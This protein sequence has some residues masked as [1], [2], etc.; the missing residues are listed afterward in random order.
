MTRRLSISPR[1]DSILPYEPGKPLEELERELGLSRTVKLASNENPLGPSPRAVKAMQ[2]AAGEAHRYPD[3]GGYYLKREL[4]ATL[5]LS[6]DQIILGNGSTE[7]VEI[8]AK[9]FLP[10]DGEALMCEG[11]FIMYQ[12]ATLAANA[13]IRKVPLTADLRHDLPA[14]AAGIG[15]ATRL[16]FI[17]NPNNPTGTR[18]SRGEMEAYFAAVPDTVLTV[19]DEAYREY[20]DDPDYPD[21]TEALRRGAQ[22]VVLRTFSKV[23]GLAGVRLGWG[24]SHPAVIRLLEKV[25]SPFNTSRIA[26]AGALAAL[27]DPLHVQRS[28]R[29]N[30]T[31]KQRLENA[32]KERG[33]R[34]VPSSANF[35]LVAPGLPGRQVFETLLPL[36]V[37]VRPMDG[38]GFKDHVRITIGTPEENTRLLAALDAIRQRHLLR[39]T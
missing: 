6:M 19:V 28:T 21:A 29:L 11:A 5:D 13:R 25:R 30:G 39:V 35:M 24:I 18:V 7:I 37:I 14:L 1:I 4:A 15:P 10:P 2:I 34:F 3:G 36:G 31:E 26:Q 12:I 22:V 38:Y 32:F 9:A 17:A 33:I 27:Q 20:I 8:L 23:H 16:V